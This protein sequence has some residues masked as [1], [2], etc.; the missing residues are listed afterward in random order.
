THRWTRCRPRRRLGRKHADEI[1]RCARVQRSVRHRRRYG[2]R[3]TAR[4]YLAPLGAQPHRD[5]S[6]LRCRAPT[7]E[8]TRARSAIDRRRRR[9][10]VEGRHRP[11]VPVVRSGSSPRVHREPPSVRTGAAHP[12]TQPRLYTDLA[13]WYHLLTH[14]SDYEEEATIFMVALN[15]LAPQPIQ[16]MLELGCGGGANASYMKRRYEMT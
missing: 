15:E 3:Q 12:V 14:P 5:R 8:R 2:S 10:R 1:D 4:R 7:R 9:R 13:D 16:T 11:Y 6:V